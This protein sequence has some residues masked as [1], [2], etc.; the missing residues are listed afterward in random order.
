MPV[1]IHMAVP[2]DFGRSGH[3]YFLDS[4][5]HQS[6]YRPVDAGSGD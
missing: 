4:A 2:H 5:L 1:I 3:D 6:D